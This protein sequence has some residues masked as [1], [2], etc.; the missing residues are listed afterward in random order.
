M[1]K[2]ENNLTKFKDFIDIESGIEEDSKYIV[3]NKPPIDYNSIR[4]QRQWYR[5][6]IFFIIIFCLFFII[7]KSMTDDLTLINMSGINFFNLCRFPN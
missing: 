7:I 5:L 6:L 1:D 4:I 2:L 3:T